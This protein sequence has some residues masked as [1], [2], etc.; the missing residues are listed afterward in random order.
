M[1]NDK[2]ILDKYAK[3]QYAQKGENYGEYLDRSTAEELKKWRLTK[4]AFARESMRYI[5]TYRP[6]LHSLVDCNFNPRQT[7]GEPN[8]LVTSF[9]IIDPYEFY[10]S[11]LVMTQQKLSFARQNEE[12]R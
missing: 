12:K 2:S 10:L 7:N 1:F 4:S 9:S 6:D 11:N 3:R 8:R 5:E